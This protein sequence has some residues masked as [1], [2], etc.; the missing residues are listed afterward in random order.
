M[1][2]KVQLEKLPLCC[3]V[4]MLYTETKSYKKVQDALNLQPEQVRRFLLKHLE[5]T[6]SLTRNH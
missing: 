6:L 4:A 1:K 5:R 3:Q 2:K